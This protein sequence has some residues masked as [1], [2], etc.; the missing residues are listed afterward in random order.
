MSP[1]DRQSTA[2]Q[3]VLRIASDTS[4]VRGK[5]PLIR[6]CNQ[7]VVN[8]HPRPRFRPLPLGTSL[9][10]L[11]SRLP[12]EP[13]HEAFYEGAATAEAASATGGFAIGAASPVVLPLTFSPAG[14]ALKAQGPSPH[15]H[16]PA[17]SARLVVVSFVT[18]ILV[19]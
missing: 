18:H 11:A 16:L 7:Q 12:K 3:T 17:C 10:D 9:S 1:C 19:T 6:L 14:G 5:T 8:E 4:P 13:I 15:N 2:G